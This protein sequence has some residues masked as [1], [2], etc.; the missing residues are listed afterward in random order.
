MFQ[1]IFVLF[2]ILS[3]DEI[4]D[5]LAR[6][7]SLY[8]EAKF[9][10]A[11]Q[12]LQHADD[13]LRPKTDRQPEKISVKLQLALAEMGLNDTAQARTSLREIYMIDADYRIDPQQF[14][15]KVIALADEA[16]AE[17]NQ[18]RCQM[19]RNDARKYFETWNATDLVNL[20]QSM[21]SKCSGLEAIEPDAAEL[22]YKTGVEAYKAGQFSDALEKFK[23][24][25]KVSPKHELAAQYLE[26]TQ[27]KLQVNTDRVLLEWRKSVEAHQFK[28]AAARYSALKVSGDGVTPQVV[29]QM[30]TEYRSALAAVVESWNRACAS[31]DTPTMESIREQVPATLPDAALGDDI[32][33][34]MKTCTKKGCLQMGAQ[35]A[36]ARLKV[37]VN[38]A[39]PAAFQE[40][41]R[42]SPLTVHVKAKIDEKGDVSVTDAQ[43]ANPIINEAVRTAVEHWKFTP[44]IDQS[45]PRCAETDLPITIKG[46]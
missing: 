14:P 13:L 22:L 15:P 8:F 39:I 17:Q 45:G 10:E 9:K 4:T 7:E 1:Y 20:I 35:L 37:Q 11:I 44:I 21:K 31:S 23:M 46:Q 24:A 36:L 29:E 3:P 41:A 27:S 38:P 12:L 19:V 40:M 43:G 32:L 18:I 34:Q 2:L 6:A 5:T 42:R 26:L 28:Q 25:V 30:R 33:A 16:K